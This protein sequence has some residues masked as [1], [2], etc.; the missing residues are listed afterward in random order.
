MWI[1]YDR[2]DSWEHRPFPIE[3]TYGRAITIHPEDPD[4]VLAS[5]SDGPH[6]DNVHGHLFRSDDAGK[7]WTQ[8]TE[9][10]PESTRENINTH[11]IAFDKNGD[12]WA[13]AGKTLYCSKDR[14]V[15]WKAVW[16]AP[17]EIEMLEA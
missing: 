5:V 11:R 14:G 6:G 8:V 16:E 2:G 1:S 4:C 13:A 7:N 9:G 17:E 15:R 12:A 3:Q 10:F